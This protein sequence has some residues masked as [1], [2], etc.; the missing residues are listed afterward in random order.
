MDQV[1]RWAHTT[2]KRCR[3]SSPYGQAYA[4][5]L[6]NSEGRTRGRRLGRRSPAFCGS[7][8]GSRRSWAQWPL[9]AASQPGSIGASA[10]RHKARQAKLGERPWA[11]QDCRCDWEEAMRIQTP[12]WLV[13][14]PPPAAASMPG[15]VG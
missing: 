15:S 12:P 7:G 14:G 9:A 8:R 3:S 4:H 11:G 5:R 6:R 13:A 1:M 2:H 10:S